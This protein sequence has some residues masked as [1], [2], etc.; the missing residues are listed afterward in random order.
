MAKIF[1]D[2][3]YFIDALHRKPEKEILESLENNSIYI[4]P[5]SVHIYCYIFKIN[6]K[7][8]LI[9]EY[10]NKFELIDFSED[11]VMRALIGPTSDFEDNVQ[12]HSAANAQCDL[13]LTEDKKLLEMKFFGKV[14]V[15]NSN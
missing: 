13:F 1:L 12:L 2:T 4:S 5:L 11:V 7:D 6:I 15:T 14:R 8:T 10:I 3:N 9:S